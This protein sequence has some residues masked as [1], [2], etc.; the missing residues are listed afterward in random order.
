MLQNIRVGKTT[1]RC[2]ADGCLKTAVQ[3]L[4]LMGVAVD[5]DLSPHPA[6]VAEQKTVGIQFS[7]AAAVDS[8]AVDL[9]RDIP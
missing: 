5:E 4:P 3:K 1:L 6:Q 8:P 9:K 2:R 7:L